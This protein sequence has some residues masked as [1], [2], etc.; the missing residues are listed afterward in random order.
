MSAWHSNP[1]CGSSLP[2]RTSPWQRGNNEKT[3][4]LQC[5]YLPK[6][7]DL[8]GYTQRE[9]NAI[10]DRLNTQPR[11]CLNWATPLEIFTQLHHH[12]PV[13]LGT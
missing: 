7:T 8:S 6:G 11:K 4:G 5:E 13:A 9:L 1:P 3:N 10:A 12:L 2:I